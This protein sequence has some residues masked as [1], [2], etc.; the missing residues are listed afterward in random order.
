MRLATAMCRGAVAS[1]KAE[2]N[3]ARRF[4][5]L[6]AKTYTAA[7]SSSD[8]IKGHRLAAN[9]FSPNNAMNA[10]AGRLKPYRSAP[11]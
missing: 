5:T 9:R 2:N 6:S 3:A 8:A 7:I 4:I 10:A 1:S 11:L